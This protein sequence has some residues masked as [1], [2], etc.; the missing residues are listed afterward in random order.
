MIIKETRDDEFDKEIKAFF[1][2]YEGYDI[3]SPEHEPIRFAHWVR[4]FKYYNSKL[5][6]TQES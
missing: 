1:E 2:Y 5:S 6:N 3:P 4:I